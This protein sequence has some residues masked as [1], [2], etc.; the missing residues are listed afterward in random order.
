MSAILQRQTFESSLAAEYFEVRRLQTMTGQH[1]EQFP[2][3]VLKELVDNS[4]DAA[5]EAGV[6]P[7]VRLRVRARG[8]W[9]WLVVMDNGNG[10][11]PADA[12]SLT[13]FAALTSSKAAYRSPT[14]G[15][16]GNAMK[17]VLGIA[18]VMGGRP[19]VIEAQ[20]VRHTILLQPDPAGD[21]AV[22]YRR[23]EVPSRPGTRVAIA[24][25][26]SACG[27]FDPRR[28]AQAFALFNPHA[29]IK[30]LEIERG[31]H[32]NSDAAAVPK[33][34]N[35]YRPAV[36]FPGGD[37]RKYLPTD[38]TSAHWYDD[39][40]FAKQV[41][42]FIGRA[43][44]G[45]EDLT[46]ADF[47]GQFRGLTAKGKA[48][49]VCKQFPQ[50]ARLS[51]FERRRADL[52]R[53][54]RAMK[55]AADAPSAGVLGL[56]GKDSLC[57]RLDTWFGVKPGRLWYK[58]WQGI[59]DGVPYAVEVAVAETRKRGRFFHGINFSPSFEDPLQGTSL[60]SGEVSG[61]GGQRLPPR[62][63]RPPRSG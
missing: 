34:R 46:L 62:R 48:R 54:L 29:E 7:E 47:V 12:Q 41:F 6:A 13:N 26:A 61:Q 35:S 20:G 25:R 28:W 49:A 60:S 59:V 45:G 16:Q 43:R 40:A 37:W 39:V 27:S 3:V 58:K 31:K 53:I 55:K 30:M 36:A 32:G 14:R 21:V 44:K 52:P 23:A 56:V 10:I 11:A 51:D 2:A 18:Y 1:V 17:T 5:E 33:T 4:L 24:L 57:K 8:G 15:L 9:L 38:N 42:S 63:P 22:D 19:V 50:V